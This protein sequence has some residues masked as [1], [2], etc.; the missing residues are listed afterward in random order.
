M[1]PEE[2]QVRRPDG[3]VRAQ[4]PAGEPQERVRREA[5]GF[6]RRRQADGADDQGEDVVRELD[7]L[8][9]SVGGRG[10]QVEGRGRASAAAGDRHAGPSEG[11]RGGGSRTSAPPHPSF[12]SSW[13]ACPFSSR[14]SRA[15]GPRG[16]AVEA[17][18]SGCGR[19]CHWVAVV[20][21][22][23]RES[24]PSERGDAHRW[25]SS[26]PGLRATTQR[27]LTGSVRRPFLSTTVVCCWSVGPALRA[28]PVV[29]AAR[30]GARSKRWSRRTARLRSVQRQRHTRS[31]ATTAGIHP[32]ED[33]RGREVRTWRSSCCRR[34]RPSA[35]V[36]AFVAPHRR[37]PNLPPPARRRQQQQLVRLAPTATL[38]LCRYPRP[39]CQHVRQ[40]NRRQDVPLLV[41]PFACEPSDDGRR[42]AAARATSSVRG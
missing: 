12:L 9:A 33:G 32:I 3:D 35:A 22:G 6:E 39:C 34:R 27:S 7:G 41:S 21:R 24:C 8:G 26:V 36:V 14:P 38:P 19:R 2:A 17:R 15:A 16:V 29:G 4:R 31:P 28:C 1:L 40:E 10:R 5:E 25:A 37:P 23:C 13:H 30:Q 20:A 18:G 11:G 42:P